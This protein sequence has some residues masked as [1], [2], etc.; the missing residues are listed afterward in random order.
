ME[1]SFMGWLFEDKQIVNPMNPEEVFSCSD[2]TEDYKICRK[3]KRMQTSTLG[4][5]MNCTDYRAL[6]RSYFSSFQSSLQLS[7]L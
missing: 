1:H 6:G 5:K 3:E 4:K 2:L 7:N